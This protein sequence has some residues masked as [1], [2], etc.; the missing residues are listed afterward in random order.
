M[1]I[2]TDL[3]YRVWRLFHN[4]V[5]YAPTGPRLQSGEVLIEKKYTTEVKDIFKERIS[6]RLFSQ[7]I[8]F[9]IE[10]EL[11]DKETFKLNEVALKI[12]DDWS[13]LKEFMLNNKSKE[14]D[15]VSEFLKF[16]HKCE[17]KGF[18]RYVDFQFDK[19]PIHKRIEESG[20]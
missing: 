20:G 15:M 7:F 10:W 3:D 17:L 18:N 13:S 16:F 1:D 11:F 8:P 19:I 14:P 5:E 2:A 9:M 4:T 12:F 6:D